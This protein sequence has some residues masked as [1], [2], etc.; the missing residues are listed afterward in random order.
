MD[1]GNLKIIR[2]DPNRGFD[3]DFSR[4]GGGWYRRY[5]REVAGPH[6]LEPLFQK[7]GRPELLPIVLK[8][9]ETHDFVEHDVEISDLTLDVLGFVKR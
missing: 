4:S 6:C 2:V 8:A 5:V 9:L 1:K 3:V 7:I